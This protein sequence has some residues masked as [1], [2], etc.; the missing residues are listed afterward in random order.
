MIKMIVK[1]ILNGYYSY[2]YKNKLPMHTPI[3]F[4]KKSKNVTLGKGT[5]IDEASN[6]G[7]YT[8]IGER[9]KVTKAQIGRY[10]SIGDNVTI[11]PG[12]HRL[13]CTTLHNVSGIASY[14]DLT[15]KKCVIGNDVWIGV[16]AIILRGVEIGNGAVI[17]A[18]S[19]VTKNIDAYTVVAGVPAKVI[20]KR[21]NKE[22]IEQLEMDKWWQYD[23]KE[24][25][26][27]H[28]KMNSSQ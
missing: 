6:V 11:G 22:I 4:N 2:I 24:A 9:C 28:K 14:S 20:K 21:L 15:N 13:N 23:Y 8:Y 1:L 5:S 18:N 25:E 12:E 19:V 27:Y 17:A 3:S 7:E 26:K 16:D 10:C